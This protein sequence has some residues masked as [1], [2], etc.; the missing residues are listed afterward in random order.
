MSIPNLQHSDKWNIIISNLPGY[1]PTAGNLDNIQLFELYIK[2]FV[3]PDLSL[4]LVQSRF[5]NYQIN[6]QISQINDNL[7]DLSLTFK[8]SEGLLN[9]YLIYDYIQSMREELNVNNEELFRLNFIKELKLNI[10][11][12]EKRP[13]IQY[14]FINCFITNLT[15]LTLT[16]GV[17]QEMTFT[18]SIKYEDY[19]MKKVEVCV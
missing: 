5:R 7:G 17:D 8:V 6:H 14:S 19:S 16:Q 12:N 11:D 18:L 2:E 13:K 15:S 10:L 3:L 4:E 1:H 9:Y